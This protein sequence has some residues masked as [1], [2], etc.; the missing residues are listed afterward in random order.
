[1]WEGLNELWEGLNELWEG[2]DDLWEGLDDLWEGL[3]GIVREYSS[4]TIKFRRIL[5][6]NVKKI[7]L[8]LFAYVKSRRK[9]IK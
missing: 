3:D 2:L 6:K 7:N 4:K 1:M 8:L 5:P 9:S